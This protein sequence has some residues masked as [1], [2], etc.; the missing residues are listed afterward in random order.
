MSL[1][2]DTS[3]S[4]MVDENVAKNN[5]RVKIKTRFLKEIVFQDLSYTKVTLSLRRT[6]TMYDLITESE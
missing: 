3:Y 5:V 4:G 2:T 6:S 1:N